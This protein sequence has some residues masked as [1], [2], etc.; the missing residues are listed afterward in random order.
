MHLNNSNLQDID[1]ERVFVF[2]QWLLNVGN[3]NIGTPNDCDPEKCSW[4]DIP[5]HYCI[6]DDGDG[7]S[8]LIDFIYDNETLHYPS[9]VKLQDKAIM[10]PKND[11]TDIINNKILSLQPGRT[12]TYLR[13]DDAIP[14]A[15][16]GGEVELLYLREY[17]NT[18]SFVGLP[19]HRLELKIGTPI[20]LLRNVNIVGS[21]CNGTR[22]IVTKLLPKVIEAQ[23]IIGQSLK[24]IGVLLSELV[25]IHGQLYVALSRA[26]TP[27]GLKVLIIRQP[28]RSP[29][30]TKNIV[31]KD[32]LSEVDLQQ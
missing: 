2:A 24:K 7:I 25:F 31:Y 23:I 17:L 15:H 16:D 30:A 8:N 19:L 4:V 11:T 3:G 26:T 28:N 18:L 20:M 9:T 29:T 10:C 21:L 32:F 13:Y 27:V 14:H 22:L 12:Y 5:E 6:P 1:R